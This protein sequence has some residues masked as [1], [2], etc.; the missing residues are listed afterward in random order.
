MRNIK[1]WLYG[2]F[3]PLKFENVEDYNE[4]K[5][6]LIIQQEERYKS[7]TTKIF[8]QA[9]LRYEVENNR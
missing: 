4:T 3:N 2:T 7:T 5:D 1:V 8:K 9:L 6:A